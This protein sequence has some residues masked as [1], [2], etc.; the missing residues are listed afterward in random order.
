VGKHKLPYLLTYK[1]SRQIPVYGARSSGH[2]RV[3]AMMK[4]AH[5]AYSTHRQRNQWHTTSEW[6][7]GK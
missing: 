3:T 5:P 1:I 4:L 6:T 2:C 7:V